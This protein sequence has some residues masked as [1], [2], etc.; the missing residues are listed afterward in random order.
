LAP[1]GAGRGDD[2]TPRREAF[3]NGFDPGASF[4]Y[5]EKLTVRVNEHQGGSIPGK[6][7]IIRH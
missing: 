3:N 5:A 4:P 2:Q 7:T 1:E 6:A